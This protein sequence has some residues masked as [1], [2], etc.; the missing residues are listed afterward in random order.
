MDMA[1][2]LIKLVT[3]AVK[4]HTSPP[5]RRLTGICLLVIFVTAP[6][7]TAQAQ[8]RPFSLS[9]TTSQALPG[10]VPLYH[11]TSEHFP[12]E[13]IANDVDVISIFPEHLGFPAEL[14]FAAPSPPPDHPWT[15]MVTSLATA[16]NL[17]GKPVALQMAL[18]RDY[19]VSKAYA[20]GGTLRLDRTWAPRCFDL[21]SD[22]GTAIGYSYVNYV[23]WLTRL[24]NP[25]YVVVMAE[26]NLYYAACGGNTAGWRALV[27]IERNAYDAAKAINPASAVFPSFKLEELYG[28][29]L[30]GFDVA[31]Y[32][33]MADLK[34]DRF[35]VS[36]YPF[37]L[38][39]PN[40][41]FANPYELPVD[42]FSRVK[43]RYPQEQRMLITETGWNS[44]SISVSYQGTCVPALVYSEP[45]FAGAYMEF[46]L[47]SAW[48]NDFEMVTWWSDRDLIAGHVMDT[49]YTPVPPGSNSC[50]AD[51]WCLS[52][53]AF[54]D[55]YQAFWSAPQAELIY[56]VFGAMGLREYDGT[57]KPELLTWWNW[58]LDIPISPQ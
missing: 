2:L 38:A 44:K 47:Y 10:T 9:A 14:F 6:T 22:M 33:A 19:M 36:S 49:C 35:G 12:L 43:I 26:V 1:K 5:M 29:S 32:E 50:G 15:A 37:G 13:M 56:K 53:A 21:S 27:G 39:G 55:E 4:R 28:N 57:G 3:V 25:K 51:S 34:R 16:A 23:R 20:A 41:G 52:I 7:G 48:V 58:A 24:F 31:Q 17:T 45:S 46:V 8:T 40:G 42:F 18:M 54:R 11:Q 30:S